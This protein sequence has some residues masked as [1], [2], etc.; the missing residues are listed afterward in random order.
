MKKVLV[1]F[2]SRQTG[3]DKADSNIMKIEAIGNHHIRNGVSYI[4]YKENI[5]EESQETS[6]M[7]KLTDDCL[8]L[9]RNGGVKQQQI[10]AKNKISTS[11]YVTPYGKLKMTVKTHRFD[12]INDAISCVVKIDY[13]LYLNDSW[14]CDNELTIHISPAN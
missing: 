1:K 14:Q 4:I 7:L 8:V 11:D 13:A 9:T 2:N 12:I 10:F 5:L 3:L 6:T